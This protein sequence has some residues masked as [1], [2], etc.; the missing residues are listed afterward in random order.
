MPEGS[1]YLSIRVDCVA[2]A[3]RRPP[4][5]RILGIGGDGPDGASWRLTE[6]EAIAAIERG[7]RFYLEWP[8]GH[9]VDLAVVPGFG[10]KYLR[11]EADRWGPGPLLELPE[12]E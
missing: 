2:R 3:G 8:K 4:Y 9:R 1:R 5:D 7:S 6:D 10:R 11:T 12:C